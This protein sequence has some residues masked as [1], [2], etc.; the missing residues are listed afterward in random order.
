M[1]GFMGFQVDGL[2]NSNG[3]FPVTIVANQG[4]G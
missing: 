1:A 3:C 2:M 4:L